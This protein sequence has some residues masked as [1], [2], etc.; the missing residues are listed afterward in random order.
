MI[1]NE[2]PLGS[3]VTV[4]A[5]F[6]IRG[7][8]GNPGDLTDPTTVT[9]RIADPDGNTS[10]PSVTRDSNGRYRASVTTDQVGVWSYRWEGDSAALEG[11]FTVKGSQFP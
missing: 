2:Y 5:S 4:R 11:Q 10:T 6:R 8:D 9:A 3:V 7:T 1:P